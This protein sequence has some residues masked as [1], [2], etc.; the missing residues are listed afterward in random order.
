MGE[1][2]VIFFGL[3]CHRNGVPMCRLWS[4]VEL[5]GVQRVGERKKCEEIYL[6][7]LVATWSIWLEI[8]GILIKGKVMNLSNVI[9]NVLSWA[10]THSLHYHT[11][12]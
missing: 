6:I 5:F 12:K 7:L 9:D 10:K 2:N 3:E 8:N 4:G 11:Q 1:R